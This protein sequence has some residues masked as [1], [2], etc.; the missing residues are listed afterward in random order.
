MTRNTNYV[1]GRISRR[2]PCDLE[3]NPY[4]LRVLR[5]LALFVFHNSSVAKWEQG[6]SEQEIQAQAPSSRP[7]AQAPTVTDPNNP[8]LATPLSSAGPGGLSLDNG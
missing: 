3:S 7:P 8:R 2:L 6:H 5:Y 4:V 1:K